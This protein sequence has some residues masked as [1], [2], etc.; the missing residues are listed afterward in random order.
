MNIRIEHRCQ[1][2]AGIW[3]NKTYY[4]NTYDLVLEMITNTEDYIDQNVSIERIKYMISSVFEHA[5]FINRD[6]TAQ[7]KKLKKAGLSV[8]ELPLDPVDQVVNIM[9]FCKLS[10]I[11]DDKMIVHTSSLNSSAGDDIVFKHDFDDPI[12]VFADDEWWNENHPW[13]E[14]L[15]D[16]EA[17]NVYYLETVQP[18]NDLELAWSADQPKQQKHSAKIYHGNFKKNETK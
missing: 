6:E 15:E 12:G 5:V 14:N 8:V 7:V 11:L 18:W 13:A 10:A 2:W 16:P 4:I 1:F 17:S 3:Y 9:L